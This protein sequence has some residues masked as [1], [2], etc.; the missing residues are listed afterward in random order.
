MPAWIIVTTISTIIV[1]ALLTMLLYR[2][3]T[4]ARGGVKGEG[5]PA[6]LDGG[7]RGDPEGAGE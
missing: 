2:L 1:T 7:N 5:T 6:A 4:R 3:D